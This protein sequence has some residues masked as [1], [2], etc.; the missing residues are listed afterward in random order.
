MK[1]V[2]S[3]LR[4]HRWLF[5]IIVFTTIFFVPVLVII[6]YGIIK[7]VGFFFNR[8]RHTTAI[9]LWSAGM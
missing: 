2:V 1:T 9:L 3:F 5:R 8:I 4:K 7:P 6:E